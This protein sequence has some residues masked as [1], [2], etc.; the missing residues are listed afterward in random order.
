MTYLLRTIT[1]LLAAVGL[2]IGALAAAAPAHA[3]DHVT[4]TVTELPGQVRLMPGEK[5]ELTLQ[6]NRTTGYQWS[7]STAGKKK[8]IKVSKGE[9]TPSGWRHGTGTTNRSCGL[10]TPRPALTIWGRPQAPLKAV[11]EPF[12]ATL[13]AKLG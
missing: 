2:A 3:D 5:I 1:A 7:A 10:F 8:A 12:C 6:T 13:C 11:S 4:L 9:Y